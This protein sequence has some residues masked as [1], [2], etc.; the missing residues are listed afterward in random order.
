M[1]PEITSGG[2]DLADHFI[3]CCGLGRH[4]TL[5]DE[6]RYVISDDYSTGR[7]SEPVSTSF[8]S[9]YA[10]D[11]LVAQAA[12]VPLSRT[13]N[14]LPTAKMAKY[15][16][17]FELIERT[18]INSEVRSSA[19]TLLNSGFSQTRLIAIEAELK[20]KL[21]PARQRY[22]T[23]LGV[24]RQ[25]M[26][27]SISRGAF[28]DE[29]TEFTRA[30]AGKL[31]FGIYSFC[32][33]RIFLNKQIDLEIKQFI[34]EEIINYPPLICKEL[35][36]NLM[37]APGQDPDLVRFT[38]QTAIRELNQ[39]SLTDIYLL[40]ALKVSHYTSEESERKLMRN[41]EE[42]VRQHPIA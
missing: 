9:I 28:L 23:F 6:N 30:V 3:E 37:A 34:I 41:I 26:K 17:L 14:S 33:D 5:P 39:R 38:T 42:K 24:V 25:L 36:S 20:R 2:S 29:F 8:A 35:L 11:V 18:A 1:E 40:T 32:L 4:L 7:L 27:T 15:E 21:S 22:R 19:E 13:A 12:V 16:K 31:D 10:K